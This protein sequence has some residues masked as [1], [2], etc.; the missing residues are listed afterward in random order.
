MN[1]YLKICDFFSFSIFSVVMLGVVNII[2]CK[3]IVKRN[4]KNFVKD[5]EF[6]EVYEWNGREL[7]DITL[8]INED[9]FVR[10][11]NLRRERVIRLMIDSFFKIKGFDCK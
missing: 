3:Q 7:F 4:C 11:V 6:Y 10:R 9:L 8:L 1:V 5:A 2:E